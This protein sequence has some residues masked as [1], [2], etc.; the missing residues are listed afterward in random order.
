MS[1]FRLVE[2]IGE[3]SYSKVYKA[4]NEIS[5]KTLAVKVIPFKNAPRKFVQSR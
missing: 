3:G 1:T 2:K 5:L 4:I